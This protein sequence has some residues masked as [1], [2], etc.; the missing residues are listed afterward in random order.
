MKRTKREKKQEQKKHDETYQ[1]KKKILT[2]IHKGV[3]W[4]MIY[5]ATSI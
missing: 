4:E 1:Q 5:Y 2:H 3:L